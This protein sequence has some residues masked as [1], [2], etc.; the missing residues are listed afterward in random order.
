MNYSLNQ[1]FEKFPGGIMIPRI[2]RG[3]VQG[4]NDEKGAEIRANFV[5]ALVSAVFHKQK[6]SLDFIY[7]VEVPDKSDKPRLFPLDG[8]QRLSTLFLMAWLCGKWDSKCR[9]EYESRRILLDL[10]VLHLN[11]FL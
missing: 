7:G 9:F 5:P 3:Y 10:P 2:Q 11:R 6:L 1:L 4:R 8:Q